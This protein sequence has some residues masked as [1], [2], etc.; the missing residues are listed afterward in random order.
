MLLTFDPNTKKAIA[1]GSNG[2]RT[3]LLPPRDSFNEPLSPNEETY[4]R[5]VSPVTP[6]GDPVHIHENKHR[7]QDETINKHKVSHSSAVSPPDLNLN[8]PMDLQLQIERF[9]GQL[10]ESLEAGDE[11]RAIYQFSNIRQL[12]QDTKTHLKDET[13]EAFCSAIV[14]GFD[15]R[16]LSN[17]HETLLQPS[18]LLW[19]MFNSLYANSSNLSHSSP[20]TLILSLATAGT[21]SGAPLQVQAGK[22]FAQGE[23]YWKEQWLYL[24]IDAVS[25]ANFEQAQAL[26]EWALADT[27]KLS[28]WERQDPENVHLLLSLLQPK[29]EPESEPE[30]KLETPKLIAALPSGTSKALKETKPVEATNLVSFW[31]ELL[32]SM[33]DSKLSVRELYQLTSMIKDK[34][35]HGQ[36]PHEK[37]LDLVESLLNYAIQ[38]NHENETE[39]ED[40]ATEC[41]IST[42]H[43]LGS[44]TSILNGEN[45]LQF[46]KKIIPLLLSPSYLFPPT[47]TLFYWLEQCV[48]TVLRDNPE[49]FFL[50]I[51]EILYVAVYNQGGT[52]SSKPIGSTSLESENEAM[53]Y[54]YLDRSFPEKNT[55]VLTDQQTQGKLEYLIATGIRS[56]SSFT[57]MLIARIICKMFQL[58][59]S[60]VLE[61]LTN[62]KI[63]DPVH[64][65]IVCRYMD[66]RNASSA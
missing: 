2:R 35:T 31:D 19:D 34:K 38:L 44:M 21:G 4:Q 8:A 20:S 30:V 37:L 50:P 58:V 51:L 3:S 18:D 25:S 54:S 23:K 12:L 33:D 62:R 10:N 27:H 42:N 49:R 22:L 53:L 9:V 45:I 52:G 32:I 55:E 57:R 56:K 64:H 15:D 13:R 46:E 41:L 47:S 66:A 65:R 1:K 61:D 16:S 39:N 28:V 40:L 59:G 29:T 60:F 14:T 5:D 63:I 48:G 6:Q 24:L 36:I 17:F 26:G 43:L 11:N 7:P